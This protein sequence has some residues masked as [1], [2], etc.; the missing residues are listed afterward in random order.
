MPTCRSLC[1]GALFGA[2]LLLG[3]SDLGAQGSGFDVAYGRWWL[4]DEPAET[5]AAT[6]F[7]RLFGPFDYGLGLFHVDDRR[8]AVDRTQTGGELALGLWRDGKGP[9][10]FGAGGLGMRHRDGNVDANWRAGAGFA[11]RPFSFLSLSVEAAYRV[12]DRQVRGFWRLDPL[13]RRGWWLQGRLA[14]GSFTAVPRAPRGPRGNPGRDGFR[15]PSRDAIARA[16]GSDGM[17]RESAELAAAVVETALDVMGTPY[18][19]GGSDTDGY[20][21]SGLI[22][23]AYGENG[24][25]LPRVSRSQARMGVLVDRQV[26]ALR[27]G[28]ILAFAVNGRGVSHVGLYVGD[29]TFIHSA[30]SGVKLSSLTASDPDSRWWRQRW[31]EARRILN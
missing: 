6:Y 23:Y 11:L 3:A 1:A 4:D 10:L 22:H 7:H 2:C 5:F 13:D 27:P 29:G 9:Y 28:D 19:W 20:D 17:S 15:A 12:E 24:I 14:L 8:S 31:V 16:A 21:C 18:R 26:A 30:S 25:L